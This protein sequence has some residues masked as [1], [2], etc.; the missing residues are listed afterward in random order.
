MKNLSRIHENMSL[1]FKPSF[2]KEYY[3]YKATTNIEWFKVK[4]ENM[5]FEWAL[6]KKMY[7]F[8]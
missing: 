6:H 2:V 3:I 4:N 5:K 7:I 8:L 1:N